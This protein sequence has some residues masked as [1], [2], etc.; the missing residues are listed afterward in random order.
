[1]SLTPDQCRAGRALLGW[2]QDQLAAKSKVAKAT[3]ANF[4]AY[5]REPYDRTL[6]DLRQV[7]EAAGVLFIDQ[8]GEGTGA[9]LRKFRVGDCVFLRSGTLIWG[10]RQDLKD[11]VGKVVEIVDDGSG[12]NR[13]TVAYGDQIE[14]V[15]MSMGLFQ[16]AGAELAR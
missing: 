8:N 10:S 12:P 16:F 9:R 15:G 11:K 7:M 14:F 13:I 1:M 4:E 5:K 3:I 6:S 2:S